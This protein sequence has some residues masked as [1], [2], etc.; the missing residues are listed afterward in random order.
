MTIENEN[1]VT[2]TDENATIAVKSEEQLAS[3]RNLD[4]SINDNAEIQQA[5]AVEQKT[6]IDANRAIKEVLTVVPMGLHLAGLK[7]AAAAWTDD[8]CGA[9][10]EALVPVLRKYAFG[11]RMLAYLETG[12]G[13]AEG[14]LLMALW[15]VA[16]A[17]YTGYLT[18]QAIKNN[19]KLFENEEIKAGKVYEA[20]TEKGSTYRYEEGA[21][22]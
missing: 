3:E 17:T 22:V 13:I 14:V 6:L 9:I 7:N 5:A 19:A 1:T 4:L 2:V 11:Q 16:E 18:D 20:G 21:K 15:P 8:S 10:S 12:G